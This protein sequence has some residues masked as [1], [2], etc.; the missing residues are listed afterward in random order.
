[1]S[2][3]IIPFPVRPTGSQKEPPATAEEAAIKM[4]LDLDRAAAYLHGGLEAWRTMREK[5]CKESAS[6]QLE[7]ASRLTVYTEL[8]ALRLQDVASAANQSIE[9]ARHDDARKKGPRRTRS[10]S[11]S[12]RPLGG[13]R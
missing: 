11:K 12:T 6:E 7:A 13:G 10:R 1:M 8:F 5:S 9:Q 3:R 4:V 2:A